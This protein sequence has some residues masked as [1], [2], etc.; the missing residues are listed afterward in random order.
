MA[1]PR[2]PIWPTAWLP[3]LPCSP[4]HFR[5]EA[6]IA[7]GEAGFPLEGGVSFRFLD[8]GSAAAPPSSAFCS[9]QGRGWIVDFTIILSLGHLSLTRWL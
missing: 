8:F 4:T 1:Q 6:D 7:A 3:P 9:L 5:S 2:T